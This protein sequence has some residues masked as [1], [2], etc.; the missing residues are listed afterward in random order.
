MELI[1]FFDHGGV[2]GPVVCAKLARD[3]AAFQARSR[4]VGGGFYVLYYSYH[5]LTCS[6]GSVRV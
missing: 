6:G 2:V 1:E 4:A 5:Y 3:F